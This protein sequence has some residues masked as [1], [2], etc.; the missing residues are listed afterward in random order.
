MLNGPNQHSFIIVIVLDT[1][2]VVK[3]PESNKSQRYTQGTVSYPG[4]ES[5]VIE[6]LVESILCHLVVWHVT[7]SC[8]PVGWNVSRDVNTGS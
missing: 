1:V 6:G 5:P 2:T 8:V 7:V 4:M 3:L